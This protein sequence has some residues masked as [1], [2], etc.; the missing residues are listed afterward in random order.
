MALNP[1]DGTPYKLAQLT[2][3]LNRRSCRLLTS[4]SA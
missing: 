1:Y 3:T 4:L 2:P